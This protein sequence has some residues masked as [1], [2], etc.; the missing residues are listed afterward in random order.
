MCSIQTQGVIKEISILQQDVHMLTDLY[1]FHSRALQQQPHSVLFPRRLW[2][3]Y[4][5]SFS[6]ELLGDSTVRVG[7]RKANRTHFTLTDRPFQVIALIYYNH[8]HQHLHHLHCSQLQKLQPEVTVITTLWESTY[9]S[10]C[11]HVQH[12]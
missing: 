9:T 2:R 11:M 1:P 10:P 6:E 4:L 3:N 5:G 8:H 12:S 7:T